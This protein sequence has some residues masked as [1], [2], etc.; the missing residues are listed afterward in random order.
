MKINYVFTSMKSSPTVRPRCLSLFAK[1][2]F[3]GRMSEHEVTV[4]LVTERPAPD[5]LRMFLGV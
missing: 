3:A 2:N 5:I 4:N 1:K